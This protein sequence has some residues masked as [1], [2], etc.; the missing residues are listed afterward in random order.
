MTATYKPYRPRVEREYKGI[1]DKDLPIRYKPRDF[2][3]IG[4]TTHK[5]DVPEYPRALGPDWAWPRRGNDPEKE[6]E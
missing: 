1:P 6:N 4:I 3:Y 2:C 5:E